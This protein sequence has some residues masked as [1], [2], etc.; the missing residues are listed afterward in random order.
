MSYCYSSV[1][2]LVFPVEFSFGRTNCGVYGSTRPNSSAYA[3]IAYFPRRRS[4]AICVD[5]GANRGKTGAV[6][7]PQAIFRCFRLIV[8]AITTTITTAIVSDDAIV[9]SA[10]PPAA[11]GLVSVSPSV[12]PSGRVST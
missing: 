4:C 2:T 10:S 12:A 7:G 6:P 11:W 3:A 5:E 9:L 1:K 8:S